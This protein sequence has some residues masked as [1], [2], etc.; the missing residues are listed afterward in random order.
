ML[1]AVNDAE[2]WKGRILPFD[3]LM[4]VIITSAG[5][6]H[7]YCRGMDPWR[8]CGGGEVAA[9]TSGI[10]T[11]APQESRGRWGRGDN[12]LPQP[13]SPGILPP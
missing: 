12:T 4:L 11:S 8:G 1:Y 5:R 9:E 7:F 6:V 10:L 2:L 3:A 13:R